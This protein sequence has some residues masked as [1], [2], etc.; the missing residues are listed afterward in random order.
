MIDHREAAPTAS[1]SPLDQRGN[2]G[3]YYFHLAVDHRPA[4]ELYDIAKDPGCLH[5]LADNPDFHRVRKK[6][7]MQLETKLRATGDP[8]I[9]NGGDIFETYKRYSHLR[10]FPKPDWAKEER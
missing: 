5:N 6:L 3:A 9:L 2:G 10:K 7:A 8:R 4:E 1:P